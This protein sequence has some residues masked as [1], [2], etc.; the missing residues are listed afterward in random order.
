MYFHGGQ[1][2]TSFGKYANAI[3][4]NPFQRLI[5]LPKG[6]IEPYQMDVDDHKTPFRR[7]PYREAKRFQH[8]VRIRPLKEHQVLQEL[9]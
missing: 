1:D 8:N 4:I 6:R 7:L 2:F 5:C 9:I 3:A